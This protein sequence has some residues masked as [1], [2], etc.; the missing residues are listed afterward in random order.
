MAIVNEL[1][2]EQLCGVMGSGASSVSLSACHLLQVM[3]E[4]LTEGMKKEIR[5]KDEA[6]VQG[7]SS[8]MSTDNIIAVFYINQC[9]VSIMRMTT[10]NEFL[11]AVCIL[12]V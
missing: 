8:E 2:M 1:G 10:L 11:F 9:Y 12:H 7:R 4:A 5:G 3:F 6:I